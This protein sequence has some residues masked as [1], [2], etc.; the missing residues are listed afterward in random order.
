MLEHHTMTRWVSPGEQMARDDSSAHLAKNY[1]AVSWLTW[2]TTT[3]ILNS[4]ARLAL[5]VIWAPVSSP[6]YAYISMGMRRRRRR[7]VEKE[8]PC[9]RSDGMIPGRTS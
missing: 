4:Q 6:V 1:T 7:L 5:G 8:H 3:L 2:L 9:T